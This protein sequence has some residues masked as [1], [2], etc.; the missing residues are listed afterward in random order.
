MTKEL[1]SKIINGGRI[2]AAKSQQV[3]DFVNQEDI[4][5]VSIIYNGYYEIFYY[6]N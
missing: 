6:K 5:I 1:K 4:E 3:L 2:V